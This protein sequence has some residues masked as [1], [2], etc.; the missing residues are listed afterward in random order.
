[1]VSVLGRHNLA[2]AEE[3]RCT[4]LACG[5]MDVAMGRS[6]G[7]DCALIRTLNLGHAKCRRTVFAGHVREYQDTYVCVSCLIERI[8]NTLDALGFLHGLPWCR[9]VLQRLQLIIRM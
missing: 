9:Y 6:E 8:F 5:G 3:S 1:M 4:K 2:L 7:P